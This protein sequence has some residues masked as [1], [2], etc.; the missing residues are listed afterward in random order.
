MRGRSNKRKGFT[1]C[2]MDIPEPKNPHFFFGKG[3]TLIICL[4]L[5]TC[6]S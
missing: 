5:S 2:G 1:S 6:Y 4:K 3:T